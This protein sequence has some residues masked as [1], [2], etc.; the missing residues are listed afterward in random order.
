MSLLRTYLLSW[1]P[2]CCESSALL[3]PF[4]L[5]RRCIYT[6]VRS[7]T[8]FEMPPKSIPMSYL[9]SDS[10]RISSPCSFAWRVSWHWYCL[11]FEHSIADSYSCWLKRNGSSVNVCF[12]ATKISPSPCR[13]QENVFSSFLPSLPHQNSCSPEYFLFNLIHTCCFW[14]VLM[15][16]TFLLPFLNDRKQWFSLACGMW[17]PE[18]SYYLKTY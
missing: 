2:S 15:L 17:Q 6:I 16:L 1:E 10:L 5:Y 8:F 4:S 11:K 18:L 7:Q 9:Y 12:L 13:D 14:G 3:L